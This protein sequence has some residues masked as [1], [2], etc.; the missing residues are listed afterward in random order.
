MIIWFLSWILNYRSSKAGLGNFSDKINKCAIYFATNIFLLHSFLFLNQWPPFLRDADLTSRSFV[1][2]LILILQSRWLN[3]A[4][5]LLRLLLLLPA[6]K[7]STSDPSSYKRGERSERGEAYTRTSD[8]YIRDPVRS[9]RDSRS[10]FFI[11]LLYETGLL[12]IS[13]LQ[14]NGRIDY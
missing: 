1:F 13:H 9:L 5:M 10:W 11:F 8:Y 6:F 2:S 3:P 12:Y 14:P 7:F 4:R